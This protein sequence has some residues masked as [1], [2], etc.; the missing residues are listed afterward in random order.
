M[1]RWFT[2]VCF[3]VVACSSGSGGDKD[4]SFDGGDTAS[5][6]GSDGESRGESESRGMDTLTGSENNTAGDRD[7]ATSSEGDV[8]A[9]P[10]KMALI[11]MNP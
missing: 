3:G 1:R 9:I 11:G 5:G 4:G 7:S 8:C 2:V 10:A 6:S